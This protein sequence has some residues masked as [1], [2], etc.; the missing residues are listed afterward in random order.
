MSYIF[1]NSQVV[2]TGFEFEFFDG[3]I[4]GFDEELLFFSSV[5]RDEAGGV[6]TGVYYTGHLLDVA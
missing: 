1:I 2:R 3:F 4:K 5:D 6:P